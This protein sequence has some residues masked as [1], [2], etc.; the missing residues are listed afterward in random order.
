MSGS[1]GGVAKIEEGRRR[2][3]RGFLFFEATM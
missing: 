1:V 2:G 3:E